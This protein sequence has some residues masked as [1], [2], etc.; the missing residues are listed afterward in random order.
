MATPIGA[1]VS[2]TDMATQELQRMFSHPELR[3]LAAGLIGTPRANYDA[4]TGM[5]PTGTSTD[6]SNPRYSAPL[7]PVPRTLPTQT[8]LNPSLSA[9]PSLADTAYLPTVQAPAAFNIGERLS[10]LAGRVGSAAESMG[11]PAV[12]SPYPMTTPRISASPGIGAS[13]PGTAPIPPASPVTAPAAPPA[14]LP[15][16]VR[17]VSAGGVPYFRNDSLGVPLLSDTAIG[18]TGFGAPTAPASLNTLVASQRPDLYFPDGTPRQ[19]T[20]GGQAV[21]PGIG[22]ALEAMQRLSAALGMTGRGGQM[23]AIV[24]GVT[25][26][27]QAIQDIQRSNL[28]EGSQ[29]KRIAE[30]RT[31]GLQDLIN[32][33]NVATELERAN[34]GAD[35]QRED[36]AA[37]RAIARE[38]QDTALERARIIG[39]SRSRETTEEIPIRI[40]P[41]TDP[42]NPAKSSFIATQGNYVGQGSSA[43][44]AQAN[45][46][47]RI[48]AP[49]LAEF[50]NALKDPA[51]R[52]R[53]EEKYKTTD[54]DRLRT[55]Y[56]R[57]AL[58]MSTT[59][60]RR[61]QPVSDY[62]VIGSGL[63]E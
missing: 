52:A 12:P 34:I 62:G 42:M 20:L 48:L 18:A 59:R 39:A 27:E 63:E 55:E 32:Q 15:E 8:S 44:E 61:T 58:R 5:A 25:P 11:L 33:R 24:G 16:G 31:Q 10:S 37:R 41:A 51:V 38:A 36:I 3:S 50:P 7:E 54:I 26:Q 60:V 2:W 47:E 30:V 23:G 1:P 28:S 9:L 46:Q 13:T 49:F 4:I 57:D 19:T 17:A 6:Y 45:L 14:T 21:D 53:M 22:Q 40:Q 35:V 56:L 29:L 43:Q